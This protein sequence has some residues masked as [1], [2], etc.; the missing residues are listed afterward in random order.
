MLHQLP[1]IQPQNFAFS[2]HSTSFYLKVMFIMTVN[3]AFTLEFFFFSWL[4]YYCFI[5]VY[6]SLLT[7]HQLSG[8]CG[9]YL[10]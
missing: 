8:C 1:G 6:T 10:T 4:D 2:V 7:G 9:L 5:F 3:Q